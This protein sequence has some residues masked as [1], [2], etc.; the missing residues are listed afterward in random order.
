MQVPW[1]CV[2]TVPRG[3]ALVP[4]V[5]LGSTDLATVRAVSEEDLKGRRILILTPSWL[6]WDRHRPQDSCRGVEFWDQV[7]GPGPFH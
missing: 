3:S 5:F 7:P 2:T 6:L 4:T 1:L